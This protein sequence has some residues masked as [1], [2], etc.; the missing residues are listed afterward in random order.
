MSGSNMLT[1]FASMG[2][3]SISMETEVTEYPRT[4]SGVAS[5]IIIRHIRGPIGIQEHPDLAWRGVNNSWRCDLVG[6]NRQYGQEG[7]LTLYQIVQ[8]HGALT[9]VLT[10]FI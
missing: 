4:G 10:C 7:R 3:R 9:S 5:Q 8:Y 1:K 2:Y 6:R